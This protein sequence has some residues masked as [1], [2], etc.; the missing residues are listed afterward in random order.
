VILPDVNILLDASNNAAVRH[1]PAQRWLTQILNG[2]EPV[3][4]SWTVLIGFIR[5]CTR[6]GVLTSPLPPARAFDLVEGWLARPNVVVLEPSTRHLEILR[7]LVEPLGAGGNV[8]PDAHLAALAIEHGGTVA[9][10]DHDFGRFKG[11]KWQDPL[12][13]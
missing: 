11:L 4:F 10:R 9:T 8:L 6:S 3:G 2:D 13:G 12:A 1:R 7:G 5:I